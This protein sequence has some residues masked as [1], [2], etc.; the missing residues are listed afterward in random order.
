MPDLATVVLD[1]R[2]HV[3]RTVADVIRTMEDANVRGIPISEDLARAVPI[4]AAQLAQSGQD[5]SK[6]TAAK[7]ILAALKHNR[8]MFADADKVSR[9]D[10][11]LPTERNESRTVVILAPAKARLD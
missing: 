9:L 6:G 3:R 4:I 5:R 8:E 10:S 7:L 1:D 11:D 2:R